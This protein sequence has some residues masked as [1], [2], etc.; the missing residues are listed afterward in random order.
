[1]VITNGALRLMNDWILNPMAKKYSMSPDFDDR[2]ITGGS[3]EQIIEET[4]LDSGS[5]FSGIKK[6][7]KID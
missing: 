3:V 4:Q 6:L 7:L 2:W 1:M 5:I